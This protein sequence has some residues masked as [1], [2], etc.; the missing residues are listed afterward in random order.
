MANVMCV[1]GKS[2]A[3]WSAKSVERDEHTRKSAG[4]HKSILG[5][6]VYENVE[7]CLTTLLFCKQAYL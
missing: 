3:L 1:G 5:I 2:T 4:N 7:L 6:I